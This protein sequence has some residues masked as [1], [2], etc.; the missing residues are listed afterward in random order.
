MARI[1]YYRNYHILKYIHKCYNV[2]IPSI[3]PRQCCKVWGFFLLACTKWV[4]CRGKEKTSVLLAMQ[5]TK[6]PL[7]SYAAEVLHNGQIQG[8]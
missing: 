1:G 6:L 7:H 2:G 5:F 4:K 3:K 8:S